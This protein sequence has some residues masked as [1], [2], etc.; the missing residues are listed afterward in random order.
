[1]KQLIEKNIQFNEVLLKQGSIESDSDSSDSKTEDNAGIVTN[2]KPKGTSAQQYCTS[3][4]LRQKVAGILLKDNVE[5]SYTHTQSQSST[6][7]TLSCST[8]IYESY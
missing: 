7:P 1:L 2:S 3:A 8:G 6:V 5:A 4:V